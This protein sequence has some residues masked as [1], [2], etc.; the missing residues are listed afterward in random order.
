M[1]EASPFF[2]GLTTRRPHKD[3]N[4]PVQSVTAVNVSSYSDNGD[5]RF[6]R[7]ATAASR[8]TQ[9]IGL[10][11]FYPLSFIF[12]GT[13]LALAIFLALHGPA[14][15][16]RQ[17]TRITAI[18]ISSGTRLAALLIGAAFVRSSWAA[19]LPHILSGKPIP[20]RSLVGVCRDWL[21][22]GQLE[23]YAS[24]PSS[25]KYHIILAVVIWMALTATSA[26]FRYDSFPQ[27]GSQNAIVTDVAKICNASL[28]IPGGGYGCGGGTVDP[29]HN[30]S[31]SPWSYLDDLKT[32]G[33][34]TIYRYGQLGDKELGANVT[35]AILPPGW[36]L[37]GGDLP[38]MEV[39][40]AC[41]SLS[42]S[43]QFTGSGISANASIFVN[44]TLL[45]TLDVA[46]MPTW[47]A[48]INIYQ[49]RNDSGPLS[50]LAPW[51]LVMLTR[52]MNNGGTNMRGLTA[53]AGTYLGNSYL[54]LPGWGPVLQGIQGAAAICHFRGTTG[55]QWPDDL[56]P[57][58]NHTSNVVIGTVIDDRPTMGT[59]LL[60]YGPSWQYGPVGG[61]SL[62]EG[63][64]TYIANNTGAGVSF[65]AMMTAYIRNE[66]ALMAYSITPQNAQK[67][68][69][70]F[71]GL[72][73]NKLYISLTII[74]VLPLSA[75][76]IGLLIILHAW[77]CTIRRRRWVNRVEFQSWWLVKALRPDMYNAGYS[78]ATEKD[79]RDACE[80]FSA[81]YR[82]TQ[83]SSNVGHL[84]LC[85]IGPNR[86]PAGSP[87]ST[88]PQRVNG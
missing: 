57:P 61:N 49:Q 71:D 3:D 84:A 4:G 36:T 10:I 22:L 20:I 81:A 14:L 83:P 34:G 69:L 11:I 38:W 60:N 8:R 55:G 87:P 74:S 30:G 45:D 46:N 21:S 67:I 56:W 58:L 54:D 88:D 44:G 6:L 2:A 76:A 75:L 78:N 37:H 7:V 42:I 79:F 16:P 70:P 64:I 72:G 23:N 65:P 1:E 51:I 73:P 77:I 31:W 43:A 9:A 52:D 68:S 28:I 40:V 26:S 29:K 18:I 63:D 41:E 13:C 25:F 50:S 59:A 35:L 86:N 33:Q 62:S 17:D 5:S 32:G 85:S 48:D 24:L 15:V 12:I 39:W 80:S 53:D 82:D 19:F 66:W 27:L 47:G